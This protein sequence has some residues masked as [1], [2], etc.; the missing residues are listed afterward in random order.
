[1]IGTKS[2]KPVWWYA[3]VIPDTEEDNEWKAAISKLKNK[4]K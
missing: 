4:I 2:C 1:M 3:L